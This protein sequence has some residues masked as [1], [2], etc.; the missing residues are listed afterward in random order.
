VVLAGWLVLHI[1]LVSLR[2]QEQGRVAVQLTVPAAVA[3]AVILAIFTPFGLK[4]ALMA[5]AGRA[6][7]TLPVAVHVLRQRLGVPL[8]A[9]A[10]NLAFPLLA[11]AIM[12]LVIVLAARMHMFGSGFLHVGSTIML[13]CLT[14]GIFLVTAMPKLR[15]QLLGRLAPSRS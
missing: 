8:Q 10:R 15:S 7:L 4:W 11:S 12:G 3:D 13:G 5:W 2:A 14:Y 9:L 1:V 6:V